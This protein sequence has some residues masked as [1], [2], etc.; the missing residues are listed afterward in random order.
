MLMDFLNF[1]FTNFWHFV[2]VVILIAGI[3]NGIASVI[4]AFFTKNVVN[5]NTTNEE[6]NE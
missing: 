2:G 4:S 1:T 3:T 5:V 6:N